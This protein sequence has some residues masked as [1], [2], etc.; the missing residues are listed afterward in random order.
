[1]FNYL[2]NIYLKLNIPLFLLARGII[3]EL[4]PFDI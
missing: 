3:K 4:I 1:M 2:Y